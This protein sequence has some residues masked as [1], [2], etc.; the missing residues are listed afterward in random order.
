MSLWDSEAT[1]QRQTADRERTKQER[2]KAV[3]EVGANLA[4]S[5]GD[6]AKWIAIGSAVWAVAWVVVKLAG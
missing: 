1:K 6:I 2:I 3:G 5:A 4:L